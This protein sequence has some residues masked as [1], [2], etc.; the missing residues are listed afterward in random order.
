ME[1]IMSCS[2]TLSEEL[3]I[4]K[5]LWF[6]LLGLLA[7]PS[8]LLAQESLPE[9]YVSPDERLTLRYPEGW[10]VSRE[11]EGITII[12]TSE[13]AIESVNDAVPPGEAALAL[14][15][16]DLDP[17]PDQELFA[18]G[19]PSGI[20]RRFI[21]LIGESGDARFTEPVRFALDG[22]EGVRASGRLDSS[23]V[24]LIVLDLGQDV[25]EVAI[26]VTSAGE[27]DR[28][29]GKMGLSLNRSIIC[30]TYNQH[31]T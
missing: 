28:F 27:L 25:F 15:F 20:A 6:L 29:E 3:M 17:T 26:G 24:L 21:A 10:V 31:L 13:D 7:L 5:R 14:V 2:L 30:R 22:L 23:E 11:D 19:T 9:T 16:S 12:A 18:S 1:R 8:L 4:D